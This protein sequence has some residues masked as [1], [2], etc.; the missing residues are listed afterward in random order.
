MVYDFFLQIG[1]VIQTGALYLVPVILTGL[2][3]TILAITIGEVLDLPEYDDIA[4]YIII[5][6][7]IGI[8]F[9]TVGGISGR[10]SH[11]ESEITCST[12]LFQNEITNQARY[13]RTLTQMFP[14]GS[15]SFQLNLLYDG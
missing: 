1:C 14:W 3:V 4:Y 5:Y 8:S 11:Y 12:R 13:M 10:T 15:S 2:V 6:L 9:L 7:F